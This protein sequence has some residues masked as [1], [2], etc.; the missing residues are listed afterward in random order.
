MLSEFASIGKIKPV[1]AV[2]LR[3]YCGDGATACPNNKTIKLILS[4]RSARVDVRPRNGAGLRSFSAIDITYITIG[5]GFLYL[6]AAMVWAELHKVP[7]AK[8]M[9]WQ[10][11]GARRYWHFGCRT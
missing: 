8:R 10:P 1:T 6:V 4:G 7:H 5:R 3:A 9:E 2:Q 11:R